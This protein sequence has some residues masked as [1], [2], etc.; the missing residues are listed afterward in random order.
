ML[1]ALAF[2]QVGTGKYATKLSTLKAHLQ[3][4]KNEFQI[5]KAP[6]FSR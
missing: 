4:L 2:H 6:Q 3:F 1:I 5:L